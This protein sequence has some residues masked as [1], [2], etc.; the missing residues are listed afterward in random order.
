VAEIACVL[1][2]KSLLGEGPLWDAAEAA[3]Y[4]V[5]IK[6]REVHRFD[7]RAGR[8]RKWQVP[9][10]VGWL[11][12]RERGGLVLAMRSGFYFF[13][14]AT[15]ALECVARPEPGRP[16]NRLN[17]GK[18]D[19]QGRFWAGSMSEG[20]Y[21][22]TGGLYRIDATFGC[23]KMIDGIAVSNSLAWSPDG[24]TMYHADSVVRTVWAW[25]F[26]LEDG[27]IANRRV[28]FTLDDKDGVPDGATVDAD[29]YLWVAIW[30]GWRVARYDPQGRLD[31]TVELPVQRPT[32]PAFGGPGL[33]TMY[34]TSACGRLAPEAVAAQP[35]AGGLFD[36]DVGVK[37]LPE[38]RF[39]G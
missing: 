14:P 5:D 32:C 16:E 37:G 20:D 34:L 23:V 7:P 22:P 35:Q 2:A 11:A 36:L 18:T 17:D 12:V 10:D 28:F 29:G 13:D 31:R 26:A 1:D 33:A 6:R 8:D 3:L 9:V 30:N 38:A 25:D 15:G 27:A 21:Q 19:R 24:R 4:W 39:K